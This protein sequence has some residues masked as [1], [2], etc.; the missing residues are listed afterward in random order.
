MQR[1]PIMTPF[2]SGTATTAPRIAAPMRRFVR[3][4]IR[5]DEGSLAIFAMMLSLLMLMM[6]GIAVDLMR[7]ESRRTTLQNTLDRS[8]LAAA[9]MAQDL[10]SKEVVNDYFTKAGLHQ[11]L[12]SVTVTQGINYK[13]V[14][15]DAVA[16]TQPMFLQMLGINEFDADGHSMAEQRINNVEIMLVLDVSGSM[17]SNSKLVNLKT[18]AKTFVSTVL[19]GDDEHRISIG[20]VPFNGQVNLGTT[21]LSKYNAT[22]PNGATN[23]NC[24]DLPTAAYGGVSLSNTLDLPMTADAD[25]YSGTN[26]TTS[27]LSYTDSN[28]AVPNPANKWCP[29]LAGNIVRLPSQTI[30]TLQTQIDGLSAVGATSINA[31]MRWGLTLLDPDSRNMYTQLIASSDMVAGM[32][33]RPFDFSDNDAMKVVVLM[34][35]GEHFAEDRVTNDYKAGASNI[36]K[37]SNDGNYSIRFTS[38]R[39]ACAGANQYFVPHLT[40]SNAA[41]P[42]YQAAPWTNATS[43]GTA[44]EQTWPQVWSVMRLKYV[45]WHL[46]ARG[47]GTDS[48][49]RS[50]AYNNAVA[51][52]RVQTATTVMDTQL[53]DVC[54]MAKDGGVIVYGIAF[55]APTNG[56]AQI[57]D[58]STGPAYYFNAQGLQ[59]TTAFS[60]IASNISQLRLTQ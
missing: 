21:L 31:G 47:L 51:A 6:G 24:V 5:R 10:D 53:Q 49:S 22:L 29:P 41:C 12:T 58:C 57:A 19:S 32:A 42:F 52:M 8:T 35:D 13:E 54:S 59:I 44:V 60:A 39:P 7:Y 9:S 45:A 23:V 30:S 56:Q 46:Y 14:A 48:S 17:A 43:T 28:Y 38:G 37:S 27:Y 1:M 3:H 11:Y 40:A 16:D 25:T 33:G 18:A 4:M 26:A 36:F 55:E 50:L 34:T 20:I 2:T 15:A